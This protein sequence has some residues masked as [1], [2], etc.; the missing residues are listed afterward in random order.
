MRVVLQELGAILAVALAA[1]WFLW[2]PWVLDLQYAD[3][4]KL[5]QHRRVVTIK[6]LRRGWVVELSRENY[7][8]YAVDAA[9]VTTEKEALSEASLMMRK[10]VKPNW[11][12][13]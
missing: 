12:E 7:P 10:S 2:L 11:K 6:E 4:A 5:E 13:K 1:T 3:A 8:G 9:A